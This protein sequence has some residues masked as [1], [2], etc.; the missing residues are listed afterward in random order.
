METKKV[1][2]YNECGEAVG[3][4]EV[5]KDQDYEFVRISKDRIGY[6]IKSLKSL[7]PQP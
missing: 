7:P 6:V 5:P 4:I 3:V 2:M 1:K